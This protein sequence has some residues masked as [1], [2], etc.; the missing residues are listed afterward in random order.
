[1]VNVNEFDIVTAADIVP[2]VSF[3]TANVSILASK[4][5]AFASIALAAVIVPALAEAKVTSPR[6]ID[7]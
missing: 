4:T 2:A 1:V 5:E 6:R 3:P 7:L